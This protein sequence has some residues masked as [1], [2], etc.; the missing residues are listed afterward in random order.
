MQAG[1]IFQVASTDGTDFTGALAQNVALVA[2]LALGGALGAGGVSAARIRGLILVSSDNLAWE[3]QIFGGHD[4][5]NP[6]PNLDRFLGRWSFVT[7]DAIQIGNRW[8]YYIDGLDIPYRD[9]DLA[10]HIG[11]AVNVPQLHVQVVNRSAA[12]KTAYGSGGH[13]RLIANLEP[14]MMGG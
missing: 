14:M 6:D 5:P 13:F 4:G 8:Y 7:T 12:A 9:Y 1:V 11:A 10:Q 3:V 2:D